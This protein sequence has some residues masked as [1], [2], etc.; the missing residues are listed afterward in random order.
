MYL[1]LFEKKKYNAGN[2]SWF[3][4][5]LVYKR[6]PRRPPFLLVLSQGMGVTSSK[7]M[8]KKRRA[9]KGGGKEG[10]KEIERSESKDREWIMEIRKRE[11]I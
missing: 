5:F 11:E 10:V 1:K 8:Y 6:R 9:K 3:F 4:N 7:I 2:S